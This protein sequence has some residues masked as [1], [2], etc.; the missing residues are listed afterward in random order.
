MKSNSEDH[1]YPI[2][3]MGGTHVDV[4]IDDNRLIVVE[5]LG[6]TLIKG[7]RLMFIQDS[8]LHYSRPTFNSSAYDTRFS[9]LGTTP[10]SFRTRV[11][12][13]QYMIY[14][15][16]DNVVHFI[17]CTK[18]GPSESI[19]LTKKT[20][21]KEQAYFHQTIYIFDH[22][23]MDTLFAQQ[24]LVFISSKAMSVCKESRF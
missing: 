11:I 1:F 12:H 14:S 21:A 18:L 8:T 13:I 3:C 15:K 10:G 17:L 9:K 24:K 20:L 6:Y 19:E 23:I 2:L 5:I 4:Y 16:F 7:D 22:G